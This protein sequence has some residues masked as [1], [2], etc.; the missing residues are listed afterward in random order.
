MSSLEHAISIAVTAH[1]D[2]VDKAGKPYVLHPL[3]LM[4]KV[5][6]ENEMI[7]AVLHDIVEDTEWT[8]EQLKADKKY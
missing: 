7:S 5:Q 3:R 1:Q 6:S 4:F 8:F 2:Q